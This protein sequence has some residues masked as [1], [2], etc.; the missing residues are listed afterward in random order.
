MRVNE[1]IHGFRLMETKEIP[2]IASQCFL[3]EHENYNQIFQ[4]H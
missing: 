1:K 2:E 3:F 4:F